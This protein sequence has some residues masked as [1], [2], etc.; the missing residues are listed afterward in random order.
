M[1]KLL[2]S[3]LLILLAFTG[4]IQP[5][6]NGTAKPDWIMNPNKDGKV[7]AVGSAYR[8]HKGFTYQRKLAVTRALD[9]MALQRGVKVS[10]NMIKKEEIKN[11]NVK[12]YVDV[13]SEYSTNSNTITAHIEET[14]Q[15][16]N[17][18]ELFIWLVLD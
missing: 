17:T 16:K 3:S 4:C 6:A 1:F 9:E 11:D 13:N 2:T 7:G 18:K 15:D 10:L 12:S 14:W 5:K 8:H